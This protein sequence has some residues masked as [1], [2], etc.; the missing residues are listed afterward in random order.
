MLQMTEAPAQTLPTP[1]LGPQPLTGPQPAP[2]KL[3]PHDVQLITEAATKTS[4]NGK[5]IS[6]VRY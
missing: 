5:I 3:T 2:P 6:D 4:A 1:V